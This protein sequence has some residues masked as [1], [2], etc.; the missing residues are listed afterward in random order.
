MQHS[1]LIL[2]L[3]EIQAIK[4]GE[5][6]LKSGMLSPI[7]LD[8][9]VTISYPHILK[10]I[11]QAMA[12][13]VAE[14]D[15]DCM[16]GV[17]YT[18]LPFATAL[19]LLMDKPMVMRRKERK[20]YGLKKIIEGAFEEGEQCLVVED[21]VTSGNSVHETICP[22]EESGL[23][24]CDVVVLVDRQQGAR[25]RLEGEGYRLHAVIEL[26]TMVDVLASHGKLDAETVDQVKRY[27]SENQVTQTAT[28]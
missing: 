6:T 5:F 15:F 11:A 14:V 9:R 22:L 21:L 1:E 3:H 17:P 26:L 25:Q 24:V 12:E 28:V 19:S 13:K 23:K 20:D 27:L 8:L 10:Q 7:Y 16:C 18:A 4:F 2:S